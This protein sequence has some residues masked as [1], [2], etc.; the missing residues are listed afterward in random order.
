M[1]DRPASAGPARTRW[2]A[3][4]NSRCL[5][6]F[7][8]SKS[9][10]RLRELHGIHRNIHLHVAEDCGEAAVQPQK[11]ILERELDAVH[12]PI[13]IEVLLNREPAN[14]RWRLPHVA[15]EQ[16]SLLAE[17][18]CAEQAACSAALQDIHCAILEG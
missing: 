12:V 2:S 5:P 18:K 17:V 11:R 8:P 7:W 14:G 9:P 4:G 6:E 15:H 13:V 16:M 3:N 10:L 1:R